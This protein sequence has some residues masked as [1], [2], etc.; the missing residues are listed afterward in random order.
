[1]GVSGGGTGSIGRCVISAIGEKSGSLPRRV[2]DFAIEF[3]W[4]DRKALA[5]KSAPSKIEEQLTDD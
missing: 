1:L 4:M 2:S 5:K 3:P